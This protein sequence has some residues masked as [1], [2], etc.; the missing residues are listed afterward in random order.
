MLI[1]QI[2]DLHLAPQGELTFGHV[3]TAAALGRIIAHVNALKPLP[4]F[5]IISGDL[6]NDGSLAETRHAAHLLSGLACDWAVLPG[7]HDRRDSLRAGFGPAH[8]PVAESGFLS[9]TRNL[10]GLRLVA[11][12]TLSEGAPGGAFCDSRADWLRAEV[13]AAPEQPAMLVLHHPPMPL[14]VP[15]TDEDG[16][17]GAGRLAAIVAEWPGLRRIAAGHIHLATT[18]MW[19]GCPLVT[20]PSTAMQLTRDFSVTPPPSGFVKSAP[21]YLLHKLL[22][23]GAMV[24]HVVT[25]ADRETAYPFAP[26][27][28]GPGA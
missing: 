7:N 27:A 3:D 8:L 1:A 25:L 6:T 23:S 16:F 5:A 15:E 21:A 11:L 9:F 17:R 28:A 2:S 20:A 13:S 4:D 14:G 26:V 12:D 24:S 10:A 18:A 22:G 19:Q